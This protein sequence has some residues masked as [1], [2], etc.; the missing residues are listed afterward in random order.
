MSKQLCWLPKFGGNGQL[1]LHI[2][3]E[4]HHPWRSYTCFPE[5]CVPDYPIP[6]GTKGWATA[7]RLMKSGW[8]LI[9]TAEANYAY[10]LSKAA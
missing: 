3:K 2:R 4:A 9:P 5:L 10:T 8:T 6:Q 7:Q 1:A